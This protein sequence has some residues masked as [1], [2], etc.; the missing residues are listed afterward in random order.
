MPFLMTVLICW[1]LM[2]GDLST[3]PECKLETRSRYYE[4][5]GECIYW[6]N[7]IRLKIEQKGGRIMMGFC[8]MWLQE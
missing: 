7:D 6:L 8:Y 3:D 4:T 1:P 5:S 2:A